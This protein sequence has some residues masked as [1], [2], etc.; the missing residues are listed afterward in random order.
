MPPRLGGYAFS[1]EIRLVPS[2]FGSD[3]MLLAHAAVAIGR[4]RPPRNFGNRDAREKIATLKFTIAN[5]PAL[6]L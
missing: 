6:Q 2:P 4:K 3:S 1:F 5:L